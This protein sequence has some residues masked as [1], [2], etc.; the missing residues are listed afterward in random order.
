MQFF[1]REPQAWFSCPS[2]GEMPLMSCWPPVAAPRGGG[3][4]QVPCP[5]YLPVPQ[6]VLNS[7]ALQKGC[8]W[9]ADS[10]SGSPP[11]QM[12]ASNPCSYECIYMQMPKFK[13]LPLKL[14]YT[15]SLAPGELTWPSCLGSQAWRLMYLTTLGDTHA[16][17]EASVFILFRITF[18][19]RPSVRQLPALQ[20]LPLKSVRFL[21]GWGTPPG[22]ERFL[23]FFMGNTIYVRELG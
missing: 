5:P 19:F 18:D 7:M 2:T 11:T 21:A 3:V 1:T 23:T 13:W 16:C 6:G 22:S 8:A 15:C 14:N 12:A 4:W 17:S 10:S 9:T 20:I